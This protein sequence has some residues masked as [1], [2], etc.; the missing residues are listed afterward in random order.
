MLI[1]NIYQFFVLKVLV[2][3]IYIN[4]LIIK[5][6]IKTNFIIEYKIKNLMFNIK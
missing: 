6:T 5:K 1:Q 4:K 2:L 3:Q